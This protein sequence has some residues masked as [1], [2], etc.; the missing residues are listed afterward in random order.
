[1]GSGIKGKLYH[2]DYKVIIWY[3]ADRLITVLNA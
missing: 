2:F 1:M 3:N